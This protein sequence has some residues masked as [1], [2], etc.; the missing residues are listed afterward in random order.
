MAAMDDGG[1]RSLAGTIQVII[2]MALMSWKCP[3]VV[4]VVEDIILNK[5]GF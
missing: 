1:R 3:L 2:I 5:H 4:R